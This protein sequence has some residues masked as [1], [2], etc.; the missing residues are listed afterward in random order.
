MYE[1]KEELLYLF[2]VQ[3]TKLVAF[4]LPYKMASLPCCAWQILIDILATASN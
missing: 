4:S 2:T 3:F 1:M